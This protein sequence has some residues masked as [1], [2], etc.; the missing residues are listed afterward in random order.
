MEE[1]K[2]NTPPAGNDNELLEETASLPHAHPLPC[3]GKKSGAKLG[4]NAPVPR[5]PNIRPINDIEISIA[6]DYLTGVELA[7]IDAAC[8]DVEELRVG[9]EALVAAVDRTWQAPSFAEIDEKLK[10]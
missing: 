1:E 9:I 8:G 10:K 6:P 7:Q 3:V 2:R 4:G 5:V